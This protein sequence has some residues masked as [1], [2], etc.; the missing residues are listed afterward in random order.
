MNKIIMSLVLCLVLASPS[1]FAQTTPHILQII[2][3]TNI[4]DAL[5]ESISEMGDSV[6][7][8]FYYL[9]GVYGMKGI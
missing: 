1:G 6:N 4:A 5:T 8:A 3:V 2:P 9:R 7:E